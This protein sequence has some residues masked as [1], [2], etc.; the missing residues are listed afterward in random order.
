MYQPIT[1]LGLFPVS[2]TMSMRGLERWLSRLRVHTA[3]VED[4]K[5]NPGTHIRRLLI[6]PL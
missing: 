6:K 3:F 2:K 4:P 1:G 5:S